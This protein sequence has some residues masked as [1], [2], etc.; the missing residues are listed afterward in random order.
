MKR[1]VSEPLRSACVEKT[2]FWKV[3]MTNFLIFSG[4]YHPYARGQRVLLYSTDRVQ[5][6][7]F[8]TLIAFVV[9]THTAELWQ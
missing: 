2:M 7:L 1:G 6:A 5:G 4:L 3:K 8:A 9:I